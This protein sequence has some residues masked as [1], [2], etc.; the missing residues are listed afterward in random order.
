MLVPLVA[1]AVSGT[2]SAI[3]A[4]TLGIHLRRRLA[5]VQ[6][7]AVS[8]FELTSMHLWMDVLADEQKRNRRPSGGDEIPS[9]SF[10]AATTL[11]TRRGSGG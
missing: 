5:R 3:S 2:A 1:G 6:R 10:P 7:T 11:Q 9:R 8:D 4:W